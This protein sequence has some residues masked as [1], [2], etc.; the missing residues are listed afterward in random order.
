MITAPQIADAAD[1]PTPPSPITAE[2]RAAVCADYFGP[3]ANLLVDVRRWRETGEVGDAD[4]LQRLER[5][6]LGRA[7]V[8][9]SL[10]RE[11]QECRAAGGLT[12]PTA[13]GREAHLE[14]RVEHHQ[15]RQQEL[16]EALEAR[17]AR[18]AELENDMDD[19]GIALRQQASAPGQAF[20]VTKEEWFEACKRN[21]FD[22]A[23]VYL[24]EILA[25]RPSATSAQAMGDWQFGVET[26]RR[27]KLEERSRAEA[28]EKRAADLE[29]DTLRAELAKVREE[30]AAARADVTANT[31]A[32]AAQQD[33]LVKHTVRMTA[34]ESEVD[35]LELELAA[36]AR[37]CRAYKGDFDAELEGAGQLRKELGARDDESYPGFVRRLASERDTLRAELAKVREELAGDD[38]RV[39]C[40]S[41]RDACDSAWVE[42]HKVKAELA[43]CKAQLEGLREACTLPGD[44]LRSIEGSGGQ[45]FLSDVQ[46]MKLY[47]A[48]VQAELAGQ[49]AESGN[50]K[51]VATST[52][53]E[54]DPDAPKDVEALP[55]YWDAR[56]RAQGKPDASRCGAELRVALGAEPSPV[57]V[58][59]RFAR[60]EK[61]LRCVLEAFTELM[62]EHGDSVRIAYGCT[63]L[64]GAWEAL[65]GKVE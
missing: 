9:E 23:L 48:R 37:M 59:A 20:Q 38:G 51:R 7:S 2:D 47:V 58:E 19:L 44:F 60:H 6:A 50:A 1:A 18:I 11:L 22:A 13:R 30:L 26:E 33:L 31:D 42:F 32:F 57:D 56:R 64:A 62:T 14:E 8:R 40:M 15:K 3:D 61:V 46:H 10:E 39:A 65:D 45:N 28:A 49:L 54:P 12:M 25:A 36:S 24:N 41:A 17:D 29:R 27:I 55:A 21:N 16:A 5:L 52:P 53:V 35:R 4:E 43:A 34:A 63:A